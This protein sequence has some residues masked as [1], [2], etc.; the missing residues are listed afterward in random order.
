MWHFHRGRWGGGWEEE[1]SG[2]E[3]APGKAER[4]PE[5]THV[6]FLTHMATPARLNSQS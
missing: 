1:P 3:A 6:Q 2:V 4:P 5:M